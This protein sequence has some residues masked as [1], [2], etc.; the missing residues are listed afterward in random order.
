MYAVASRKQRAE[1]SSVRLCLL[2]GFELL[3]D[4]MSVPLTESAQRLLVFLALHERPQTRSF[5]AGSM[6]PDKSEHRAAA[7]LRSCLWRLPEEARVVES[8]G[9]TLRLAPHIDVDMRALEVMGWALIRQ[10]NSASLP[11]TI[12]RSTFYRELLPG[13]YDDWVILERER[14]E[15]LRLHFLEALVGSLL[16]DGRHAEAI[17]TALRLVAADPLR[18]RSQLALIW[19]YVAE[20]SYG[21]AIRQK[22]LYVNLIYETFGPQPLDSFNQNLLEMFTR[23][24]SLTR[25]GCEP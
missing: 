10:P 14:L 19:A 11:E 6:W 13:W 17:E 18:E 16:G 8:D 22:E 4:G 1:A 2:G 24:G 7:N 15:Q 21:A 23:R 25:S 9:A 12:D 20:G 3:L 5:V